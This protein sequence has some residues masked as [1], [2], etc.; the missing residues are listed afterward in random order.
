MIYINKTYNYQKRKTS[1]T[2]SSE[3]LLDVSIK[4]IGNTVRNKKRLKKN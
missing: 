2:R 1:W 3:L 4:G